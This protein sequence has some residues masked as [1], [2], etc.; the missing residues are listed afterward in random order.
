MEIKSNF[1]EAQA[2]ISNFYISEL[3]N[4]EKAINES[5]KTLRMH[6]DSTQFINQKISSYRLKHDV[7]QAKYL[8]SKNSLGLNNNLI[9]DFF[10]FFIGIIINY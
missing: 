3:Y 7:Q 9:N 4:T 5:Y 2:N 10:F 1:V 6:C 8:S